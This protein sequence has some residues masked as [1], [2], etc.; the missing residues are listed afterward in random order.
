MQELP[1]PLTSVVYGSWVEINPQTAKKLGIEEGDVLELKSS[2]GTL[3]APALIYQGVR[4]DVVAVPIGQG[5][6]QF[7]RYASGRGA[8]PF[9]LLA[10]LTDVTSGALAMGA[11]RVALRKTGHHVKIAK[12]DGVSR[13]WPADSGPARKTRLRRRFGRA[14]NDRRG[15]RNTPPG[16]LRTVRVSL[17]DGDR[18]RSLQRLRRVRR[19]LSGREQPADRQREAFP[20]AP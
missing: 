15:W 12:T 6:A 18:P 5:H 3:S 8:N 20:R 19:R 7:G 11:T 1:D 14:V 17:G 9:A 13:T 2:Q 10:P 16:L 4:P